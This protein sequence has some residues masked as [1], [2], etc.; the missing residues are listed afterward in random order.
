[1]EMRLCY[2]SI[3]LLFFGAFLIQSGCGRKFGGGGSKAGGRS[4]GSH[5]SHTSGGSSGGYGRS[6]SSSHGYGTYKGIT[7]GSSNSR[8][9]GG[10]GGGS[11]NIF[12]PK[13]DSKYQTG[14]LSYPNYKQ[15]PK[16]GG[17]SF[18]FCFCSLILPISN[19]KI[20]IS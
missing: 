7:H 16:P 13:T 8:G 20:F 15:N 12:K 6:G 14:S 11:T 3:C 1:M 2:V 5:S 4:S 10:G 18:C 9:S 19:A 17:R